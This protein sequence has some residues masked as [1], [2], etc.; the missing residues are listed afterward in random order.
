M[1]QQ[2]IGALIPILTP[3]GFFAMVVLLVWLGNR[4][5]QAR[6]QARAEVQKRLIDKFDSGRELAEFLGSEG[7]KRLLEALG[8][9]KHSS[10]KW[11]LTMMT[12]GVVLSAFG[13]GFLA[14]MWKEPDLV[15]PAGIFLSLGIGFLIAAVVSYRLSKKWGMDKDEK[16]RTEGASPFG[17][18]EPPGA[19][20]P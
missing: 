15:F 17:G 13:I 8:E 7:S 4:K 3:L 6:I 18:T 2:Q 1:D 19:L 10:R 12:V 9:D 11:V 14:V 20:T 5:S 16:Q